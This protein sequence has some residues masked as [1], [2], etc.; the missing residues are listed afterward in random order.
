MV[1]HAGVSRALTPPHT[2]LL[3]H[4][5]SAVTLWPIGDTA[6]SEPSESYWSSV[7]IKGFYVSPTKIATSLGTSARWALPPRP[8]ASARSWLP[9]LPLP[10]LVLL[11]LLPVP[12]TS[13]GGR[14]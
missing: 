12:L 6:C 13:V 3:C 10:P 11:S 9:P 4:A 2:L 8:A 7:K 1:L 5:L 14:C